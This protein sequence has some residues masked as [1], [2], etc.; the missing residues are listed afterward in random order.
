MMTRFK[1]LIEKMSPEDK[2]TLLTGNGLWHSASLP[3]LDIHDFIMTDGTYGVRYSTS[4]IE[5][6]ENWNFSDFISVVNQNAGDTQEKAQ[7]KSGSEALF[8]HS[9]PA[10]CFPN[11]S[12]LACSWDTD[13]IYKMGQAL[14]I[15]CQEMGVG[16]L[17][18]PGINIR[19][20]PLAGRGYEYYS[21]DPV[22]SGDIA[23]ALINGLQ[24]QGVGA[25]LKHFAC[26]NS[27][28]MRTEMD[29]VVE[30]RALREIYLAGFQRAIKKSQPWTVMSSYNLLNG[31]QTSQ[32]HW[33]LTEVL[34]N[35]WQYDGLVISDWYGVKD[36]PASLLAGND[37]AMP[38]NQRDKQEL[39]AAIKQGEIPQEILDVA[40]ERMLT[41]ID[42]VQS[43]QK[44]EVKANFNAHHLLAQKIAAESL[45]LLKNENNILPILP[46]SVKK[47]AVVGKPAQ[48]PVIQ[49]SGCATTVPWLLDRP[50]DEIFEVA[51]EHFDIHYAI[52]TPS[53]DIIDQQAIDEAVQKA[54][55][56]D[57]A[58]VFVSTAI[59]EDGENGDRKDLSILPTHI[60]LLDE[61]AKVQPNIVVVLAN[62]DAV[63]MPWLDKASALLETFF[64]GQGMGRAVADALFGHINPCG[65]LTVTMPN[66]L[67]ETPA[68]LS[69]PGENLRHH[70][71]EGLYVGYRY[72]DKRQIVPRF[73]FGFGL[74]YTHFT[75]S[76]MSLS[77]QSI[78]HNQSITVTIDITN[79]GDYAGKEIVQLYVVPPVSRLAREVQSLKAFVKVD[80]AVNETKQVSFTLEPEDFTYY[81]PHFDEWVTEGGEY[82]IRVSKSSR[83]VAATASLKVTAP[84]KYPRIRMDS[85]VAQ[86]IKN[87][88]V[89][90][91]IAR[92]IASKSELTAEL[93]KQRLTSIAPELFSGLLI[94]LTEMLELDISRDE[95]NRVL[96]KLEQN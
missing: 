30:E 47:I 50:L 46:G 58:I 70:Y 23:A 33:L 84:P 68:F 43:H 7:N 51:S 88:P 5:Q 78:D 41:L 31:Q 60:R 75:Y 56:A 4:Q 36:R 54:K 90:D 89:F 83:D 45:V 9:K 38:E 86:L 20:T 80:L 40:C 10:T 21:E 53:D 96:T 26:N 13:L 1:T 12:S 59:G 17:L 67:E 95:L 35:E 37:L 69:Y 65:K 3:H 94:T 29:S 79:D 27:E 66:C 8:S 49:G 71:S 93:A 28:F 74:S 76:N 61:V 77:N 52:G 25:S 72:Y 39:L 42:K 64:A 92:L 22:I 18:G 19:R 62:S 16:L 44:K 82:Q 34:R 11:G 81:D 85:S 55:S 48:E 91:A 73:P 14:A 2:V 57:L 15:E 32:N 6:G 87:P 63:I 24:E